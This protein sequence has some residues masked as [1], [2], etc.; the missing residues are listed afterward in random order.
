MAGLILLIAIWWLPDCDSPRKL[1]AAAL[2]ACALLLCACD[3]AGSPVS[4]STTLRRLVYFTSIAVLLVIVV[5]WTRTPASGATLSGGLSAAKP[6]SGP[7][8]T[9]L[10]L[11]F[12]GVVYAA[13]A[14]GAFVRTRPPDRD[15]NPQ[16]PHQPPSADA[17][18]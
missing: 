13:I 12:A 16:N 11:L 9:A 14:V 8:A 18:P 1:L 2:S 4:L 17:Q 6:V 15:A 3:A 10:Y 7:T 5:V